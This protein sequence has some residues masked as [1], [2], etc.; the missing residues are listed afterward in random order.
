MSTVKQRRI[1]MVLTQAE[2][3]QCYHV[4]LETYEIWEETNAPIHLTQTLDLALVGRLMPGGAERRARQ[5]SWA[6]QS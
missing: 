5:K 6:A 3:A 2:M 4:S 1:G